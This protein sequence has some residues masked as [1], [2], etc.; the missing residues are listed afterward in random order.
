MRADAQRPRRM[1]NP[2]QALV[3]LALIFILPGF[4]LVKAVF[5]RRRLSEDFHA[6]Y[7]LFLS[8]TM[9][10]VV[11]ILVGTTLGFLPKPAGAEKG[12]FQ[13][14]AT[15]FPFIEIA[16]G[17]VTL[18]LAAAAVLRGAFPRVYAGLRPVVESVEPAPDTGG[19]REVAATRAA[20]S[21]ARREGRGGE[22]ERLDREADARER[23]AGRRNFGA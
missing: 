13:G 10:I 12:Y 19:L 15:G 23:E 9:S 11:T 1:V 4:F 8:V 17:G 22:A 20:A 21:R 16:L 3:A 5:P 14:A 18:V 7:V 2:L 6:P